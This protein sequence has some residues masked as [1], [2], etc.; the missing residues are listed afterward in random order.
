MNKILYKIWQIES[1]MNKL[2]VTPNEMI[3][4]WRNQ[5]QPGME[6]NRVV[7][8]RKKDLKEMVNRIAVLYRDGTQSSQLLDKE[9]WGISFA[10]YGICLYENK[11]SQPWEKRTL[12]YPKLSGYEKYGVGD[13]CF[14]SIMGELTL[15]DIMKI[16]KFMVSLGGEA[17]SGIYWTDVISGHDEDSAWCYCIDP[18][19]DCRNRGLNYGNKKYRCRKSRAIVKLC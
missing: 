13:Y 16:N 18:D 9:I 15:A 2:G 8:K 10:G 6:I 17:L 5:P 7:S 12:Y 14:W 11:Q 1:L 3:A 4:Y 19:V